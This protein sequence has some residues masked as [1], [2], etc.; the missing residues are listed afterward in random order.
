MFTFKQFAEVYD[1]LRE[2]LASLQ[3]QSQQYQS[4]IQDLTTKAN[5][6]MQLKANI[7][8]Q[9]QSASQQQN[10]ATQQTAN[11]ANATATTPG[12]APGAG[13]TMAAPVVQ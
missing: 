2:D 5:R 7:D 1:E 8:K 12:A 9:I 6:L 4:Q 3:Q 11:T 10:N 13:G